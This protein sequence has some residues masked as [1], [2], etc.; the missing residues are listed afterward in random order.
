MLFRKSSCPLQSLYALPAS[1]FNWWIRGGRWH[2]PNVTFSFCHFNSCILLSLDLPGPFLTLLVLSAY[3]SSHGSKLKSS[4]PAVQRTTLLALMQSPAGY[5][6]ILDSYCYR[7]WGISALHSPYP[8][9]SCFFEF[10]SY[11]PV[12]AFSL[13]CPNLCV[14]P[15][16]SLRCS[17]P[18]IIS[19]AC[20]G[21]GYFS[22]SCITS[23][24]STE[25]QLPP[26]CPFTSSVRSLWSALP[27]TWHLTTQSS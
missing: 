8:P 1:A 22:P 25:A 21:L 2:I 9:P 6:E 27:L 23:F 17:I 16:A 14:S 7:I 13:K 4:Q 11:P 3:A 24:I 12:A 5:L 20:H 10:H 19:G 18:Q 26:S 15:P